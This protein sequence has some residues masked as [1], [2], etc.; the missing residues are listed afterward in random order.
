MASEAD[1]TGICL[2][3]HLHGL[4]KGYV[5]AQGRAPDAP[6]RELGEG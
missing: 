1:Q 5:R 4:H 2:A 3:H 6:V